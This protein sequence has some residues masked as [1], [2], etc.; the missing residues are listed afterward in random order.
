MCE[1]IYAKIVTL[2]S[3]GIRA[4][5]AT[6]IARKGATPRKDAAKMLIDENGCQFGTIGGGAAEAEVVQESRKVLSSGCPRILSFDLTGDDPGE[7]V[8]VCGGHMEVYLEPITSDPI[9]YIFGAGHVGKALSR[10][11]R[12]AGFRIVVIDDREKYA[13]RERFPDADDLLV[14]SW[15][16][17][18][19]KTEIS[20][21]SYMFI[22]TRDHGYDELCLQFA[23]GSP[24]SYIGMLGSLKKVRLLEKFIGEA[25]IDSNEF[26]RVSIPVGLDIGAE[27]PEE[28]AI[29]IV[30]EL[31]A[32]RKNRDVVS[33][34]N[35]V[36][37]AGSGQLHQPNN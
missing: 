8:L 33:I 2:R 17:L 21:N 14:D 4:T 22:S 18:L 11:A 36:H 34:K 26:S 37:D 16:N 1:D 32:A 12:F 5:L 19:K 3:K 15:D 23:L 13:N 31:I 9:L 7:N 30:A 35:A 25:G 20:R 28:I 6:I 27:T 24:A 10:V 29:S